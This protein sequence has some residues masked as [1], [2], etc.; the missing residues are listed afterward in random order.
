[1]INEESDVVFYFTIIPGKKLDPLVLQFTSTGNG[2]LTQDD[3]S[4][5]MEP[6]TAISHDNS[7]L[8]KHPIV[9]NNGTPLPTYVP[10]LLS[11]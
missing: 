11:E 1:M 4:I 10:F 2:I 3:G 6:A 8:L 9:T 5:S 7:N